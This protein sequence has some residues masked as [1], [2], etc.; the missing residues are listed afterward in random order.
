MIE[1]QIK[2]IQIKLYKYS[3][4]YFNKEKILRKEGLKVY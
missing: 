4:K 2:L 1:L 3:G